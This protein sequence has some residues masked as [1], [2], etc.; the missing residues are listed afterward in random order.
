MKKVLL[1]ATL[2]I[3]SNAFASVPNCN[4]IPRYLNGIL[5][6]ET[7]Y[8]DDGNCYRVICSDE[9]ACQEPAPKLLKND[10]CN[11]AQPSFDHIDKSDECKEDNSS[12][13]SIFTGVLIVTPCS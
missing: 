6:G 11:E 5:I 9:K 3:Y 10:K 8:D 7:A 4:C 1:V 13:G 12:I 2:L